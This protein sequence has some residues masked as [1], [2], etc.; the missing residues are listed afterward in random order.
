MLKYMG[1]PLCDPAASLDVFV[2]AAQ[3]VSDPGRASTAAACRSSR[4]LSR[5]PSWYC[6]TLRLRPEGTIRAQNLIHRAMGRTENT[7]RQRVLYASRQ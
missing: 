4:L 3:H 7:R 1:K 5:P 6:S 2:A